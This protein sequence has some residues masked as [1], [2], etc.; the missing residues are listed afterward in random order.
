MGADWV[1]FSRYL[2]RAVR[3]GEILD[4]RVSFGHGQAAAGRWDRRNPLAFRGRPAIFDD[5]VLGI[6]S[7]RTAETPKS[8]SIRTC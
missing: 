5:L 8:L 6:S 3:M 2:L 1:P 4:A 7:D